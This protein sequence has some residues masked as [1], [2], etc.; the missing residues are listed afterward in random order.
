MNVCGEGGEYETLTRDCP[1]FSKRVEMYV[2]WVLICSPRTAGAVSVV[3][4]GQLESQPLH[5]NCTRS[6]EAEPIVMS[7][8]AFAPTAYLKLHG[9]RLAE[10]PDSV[11]ESMVM[12]F[13]AHG[14]V[15]PALLCPH[16]PVDLLSVAAEC[17]QQHARCSPATLIAGHRAICE[18]RAEPFRVPLPP[19]DVVCG[20][21]ACVDA[22]VCVCARAKVRACVHMVMLTCSLV[23]FVDWNFAIL[24]ARP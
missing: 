8:D 14:F 24:S 5:V 7:D 12:V 15:G 1:L 11:R 18:H 16:G 20:V 3:R 13:C 17:I 4:D 6:E 21:C 19:H 10:K 2:D 9:L 22:S 23:I